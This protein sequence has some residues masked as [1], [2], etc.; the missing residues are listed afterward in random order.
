MKIELIPLR[1]IPIIRVGDDIPALILEAIKKE[2]IR[3]EDKDVL[4]VAHTIISRAKGYL[5]DLSKIKPSKKAIKLSEMTGKP[6]ELIELILQSADEILVVHDNHIITKNK[7]GIICA[8]SAVDRSNS[9]GEGYAVTLPDDPDKEAKEIATY[10]KEKTGKNIAVI[11][12][13]T[14]GRVLREGVINVAIGV[15]GISPL[16]KVEKQDLFGYMLQ[17]TTVCIADELASSAELL[18]GQANEKIPVV[19]IKGFH[20]YEWCDD[21]TASIINRPLERMLFKPVGEH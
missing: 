6:P 1:T 16:S 14:M 20:D 9:N 2:N 7:Q 4:I 15:H 17:H 10:L 21:T 11:I 3:L 13:D 8:N 18:M 19:L 12:S 5:H